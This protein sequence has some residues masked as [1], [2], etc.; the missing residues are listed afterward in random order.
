TEAAALGARAE[1]ARDRGG[2]GVV[3]L[4]VAVGVVGG[5][6]GRAAGGGGLVVEVAPA[7]A[8]EGGRADGEVVRVGAD[9][10]RAGAVADRQ[11]AAGLGRVGGRVDQG[12]AVREVGRGV[13]GDARRARE[14]ATEA[15]ALGARAE[16][17]R[18]RG[19]A[20]VVGLD[21]AVGV[22]GGRGR[23]EAGAGGLVVEV[24]PAEAVE[25]GRA[26]G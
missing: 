10:R 17:A 9:R 16:V 2:A 5:R 19:G 7:E 8:V 24:A 25:G 11:V 1:V 13:E 18:D 21:V 23:R 12:G 15:A 14:G 22:V 6:G 20:G 4:D 26:D 3:G